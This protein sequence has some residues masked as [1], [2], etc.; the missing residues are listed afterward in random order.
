MRTWQWGFIISA[1]FLVFTWPA[2]AQ[3]PAQGISQAQIA[4]DAENAIRDAAGFY[5]VDAKLIRAVVKSE[6]NYNPWAI[7]RR[8]AIGMMQLMPRTAWSLGVT[9]PF[10]VRQN[11]FAGTL[12]LKTLLEK[13]RDSN[14]AL[15]AYNAGDGA[16]S[17]YR[18]VPPYMETIQYINRIAYLYQ[19]QRFTEIQSM[20]Q[21]VAYNKTLGSHQ[22]AK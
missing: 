16:V 8:G 9:N 21:V 6:S 4:A 5:G 7:S 11:I 1:A 19:Q 14:L 17:Q 13:Y 18:G 3:A 22:P 12:Y 10:N 2:R 20:T 15:A